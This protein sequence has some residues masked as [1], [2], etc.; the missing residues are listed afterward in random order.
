MSLCEYWCQDG[1]CATFKVM[2]LDVTAAFLCGFSE[3]PLFMEIPEASENFRLM[4]R[5]VR[6]L[7]GT[8][9]APQLWTKHVSGI[10]GELGC[11]ET[12]GA[13]GISWNPSTGV[14]MVLHVDDFLFVGEEQALQDL[15][16][17]LQAVYELKA[18]IIGGD[19]ADRKEGTYQGRTIRWQEWSL[20]LE[21][22]EKHA[23]ELLRCTG[24]ETCKPV[25]SPM[26]AED[27][28][29]DDR[30]KTEAPLKVLQQGA[31]R[32]YRRGT[33]P[34]SLHVAGPPGLQCSSLSARHED[35]GTN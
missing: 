16:E 17:Q 26:T 25:N 13:S 30:K 14:E 22:N 34:R 20:E 24:M 1:K 35:A 31:A 4:A 15:K 28:K 19:K 12:K 5:L 27:F 11:P 10:L 7:Y 29:D 8:R 33:A 6:S 2:L 9:D 32:L 18:T 3:R 23:Q 21:G